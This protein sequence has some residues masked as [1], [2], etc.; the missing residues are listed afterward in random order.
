M[1]RTTLIIYDFDG[2]LVDTLDDITT[3]VNLALRELGCPEHPREAIADFVGRGVV[4]LM[5]RALQDT[6]I[7][8][9][10]HAVQL[11]RKHYADHLMD[12]TDYY[13]HGRETVAYFADAARGVQQAICSNKPEDFVRRILENLE[14]ER[15]FSVIVGGD[16]LKTR[17]PDPEGVFH[18]LNAL[19]VPPEEALLVGDSDL[20]LE[21]GR[22]ASIATCA[23]THG[24]TGRARLEALHPDHLIDDLAE[25]KQIVR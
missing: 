2:T 3:S 22:N 10:E 8:D 23:V 4:T 1:T 17:K 16:T 5:T 15:W 18:I 13:P 25:L 11:F 9:I 21:T 14:S 19:R 24:N 6:G 7:D 12:R 20:D